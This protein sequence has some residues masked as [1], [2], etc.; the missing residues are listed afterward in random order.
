MNKTKT[1][2]T[3]LYMA[4]FEGT[5]V[6]FRVINQADMNGEVAYQSIECFGSGEKTEQVLVSHLIILIVSVSTKWRSS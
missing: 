4:L 5:A 2:S 1:H 3:I 6:G